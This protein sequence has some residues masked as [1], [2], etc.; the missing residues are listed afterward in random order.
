MRAT[1]FACFLSS[2]LVV[3]CAPGLLAPDTAPQGRDAA[4]DAVV[5]VDAST[6]AIAADAIAVADAFGG[7][8]PRPD[9][10]AGNCG[11]ETDADNCGQC[12]HSCLG[13][14]CVGGMCTP[15]VL[16]GSPTK[17]LDLFSLYGLA[18]AGNSLYGTDWY[19]PLTLV[20]RTSAT[21][22]I[23]G[24]APQALYPSG[25]SAAPVGSANAIATD[26]TQLFFAIYQSLNET[27]TPGLYS[28]DFAGTRATLL[29]G[30][31]GLE[32]IAADDA[33]VY[34]GIKQGSVGRAAKDGSGFVSFDVDRVSP[35]ITVGGAAGSVYYGA[36]QGIVEADRGTFQT[37]AT[38]SCPGTAGAK[39]QGDSIAV[40]SSFVA[41]A[42]LA[43][44]SLYACTSVT[45][46]ALLDTSGV[47]FQRPTAIVL[48]DAARGQIYLFDTDFASRTAALSRISADGSSAQVLATFD[49]AVSAA[50]QDA[51]AI[52][53]TTYGSATA[54]PY[55]AIYKIAK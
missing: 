18:V 25:P 44:H 40:T 37:L 29:Q 24:N 48:A 54:P 13:G 2:I 30:A 52:Y 41:W 39:A 45:A 43:T 38:F 3:G 50:T 47:Q 16:A 31:S 22:P 32:S 1:S 17:Y 34:F 36:P 10:E 26:G 6:D 15:F 42:T 12:G 14:A 49:D 35:T 33:Y 53:F 27:W 19:E 11:S 46:C 23:A 20:Y 51:T 21:T 28:L 9:G 7:A 4:A 55:S 5:E 8:P